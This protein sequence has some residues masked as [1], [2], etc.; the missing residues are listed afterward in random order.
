MRR[1]FTLFASAAV[2]SVST[3]SFAA[4]SAVRAVPATV[5][6]GEAVTL[7]WYFTGKKVTVSG[8]RFG[9]AGATVTGRTSLIDHPLKPTRYTFDVW[10]MGTAPMKDGTRKMEPLHARYTVMV[11]VDRELANLRTY[12]DPHGWQVR[13]LKTW[14]NYSVNSGSGGVVYFQPEEDSVERLAVAILPGS[15]DTCSDIMRSVIADIPDHYERV[16]VEKPQETTYGDVP[17]V[18]TKFLGNDNTHP[19]LRTATI[20]MTF[21]RDGSAYVVSART[22]AQR[23]DTRKAILEK[24]VNSFA[25]N[26]RTSVTRLTSSD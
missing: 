21:I 1:L 23:F 26:K 5:A 16:D 15:K 17:A 11:D 4:D 18:R 14:K 19:G 13:T 8:G 2:L 25:V 7:Q 9:L 6:P 24:M 10:Y 12:S 3:A 20:V 22:V